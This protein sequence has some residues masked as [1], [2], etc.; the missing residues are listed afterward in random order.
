[1]ENTFKFNTDHNTRGSKIPFGIHTN[2]KVVSIVEGDRFFDINFEDADGATHN[3]R[4]WNPEGKFPR[5]VE[6]EGIKVK[7]TVEEAKH[8]EEMA[9]HDHFKKLMSIFLPE[10]KVNSNSYMEQMRKLMNLLNPVLDTK[11]VNLKLVYDSEGMYSE[12][13]RFPNYVEEYVEGTE[14]KLKF[15]SYD[16]TTPGKKKTAKATETS[17]AMSPEDIMR[18]IQGEHE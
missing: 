1:M 4:L 15:S 14:P 3:K 13:P 18:L 5:E 10:E 8:R 12:F 7:E 17:P 2:C 11:R 16:N 6:K 9:N